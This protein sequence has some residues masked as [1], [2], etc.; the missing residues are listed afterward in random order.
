MRIISPLSVCDPRAVRS[1][2]NS[3]T[4]HTVSHSTK[5]VGL[6][7]SLCTLELVVDSLGIL[8]LSVT[9]RLG[10]ATNASVSCQEVTGSCLV[11]NPTIL[12]EI[13]FVSQ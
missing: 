8:L 5:K 7:V 13:Y 10:G 4:K 3:Y 12:N 1:V 2:A 9:D 6:A 11:W